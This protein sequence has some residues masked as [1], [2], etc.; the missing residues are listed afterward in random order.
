MPTNVLR[1]SR[2]KPSPTAAGRNSGAQGAERIAIVKVRSLVV[3]ISLADTATA[4]RIWQ[5]LP[6]HSTIETWGQS[7]HFETHVESGRDR[8]ARLSIV[9]SDAA[10]WSEDDRIILAWGPTPISGRGEIRLMR[11]C[12]IWGRLLDDPSVLADIT[13]GERIT[14]A[15][16]P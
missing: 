6:L 2:A 5:Q 9:P 15:R 7:I 10:Y 3:R 4:N 11:P 12:N 1:A 16:Q 8:T 13:P 14:L